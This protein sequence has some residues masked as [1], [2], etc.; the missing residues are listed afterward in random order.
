VLN[1]AV[2]GQPIHHSLSPTLHHW[3]FRQ[4]GL[5]ARYSRL[6][7]APEDLPRILEQFRRGAWDGLNVTLPYKQAVLSHLDELAGE[8]QAIQAVNC[9]VRRDGRLVGYNTDWSGFTRA[10]QRN[11][12]AVSGKS[13]IVLGAGGVARSVLYSLLHLKAGS[14]WV[15]NRTPARARELVSVLERYTGNT[16]LQAKDPKEL[17]AVGSA[18]DIIIN[19]TP[20]GMA[21]DEQRSPCPA[22][23][24]N[25]NQV[26][27]DTIYIPYRT[28]F[29]KD[30]EAVGARIVNGLDMFI[31]QGLISL[32]LWFADRITEGV[33]FAELRHYMKTVLCSN[34][35]SS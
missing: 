7:V 21:P 27:I 4:L 14:V 10:L 1:F 16:D 29:L 2:I 35:S 12:I 6:E 34:G 20:V 17:V 23:C 3:L 31:F 26:L 8:A 5:E 22:A 19:C 9:L 30:G 15:V 28:R 33:D 11:R 18:A 24:L 32:D 13:I 25:S